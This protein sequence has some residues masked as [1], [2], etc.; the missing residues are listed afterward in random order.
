[1]AM[2]YS[3]NED[4]DDN[5][6]LA[7][8]KE[9]IST[10]YLYFQD[11]YDRFRSFRNFV[12]KETVNDNQRSFLKNLGR[13]MV[14]FNILEAPISSLLG[15][16]A[17]HE[18]SIEVSPSEGVPVDQQV[19]DLVEMNFRHA[20]YVANKNSFS[21]EVYKDTLTGGFS[22]AKVRT[23]YENSMSFKQNIYI[24]KA[25]DSTLCG[26]D[27][28]A[29]HSHKGDGQYCFEIYP[30][31]DKDFNRTFEHDISEIKY[32]NVKTQDDFEGFMWSYKDIKD[33]KTILVAEYYEKKKQRTRI[34]ELANGK[35]MR[36]S[37]YKKMQ[38]LWEENNI[39]EQFPIIKGKPRW[40]TLETICKYVVCENG[41]LD[42]QETDYA[43]LPLIF[44]DGNSI[45]LTVG[46][47]NSTYQMT[48][49]YVYNAKGTQDLKNFAGQALANYL[50]NMV[51]HK[52]IIKKEAIV[53]DA[54]SLEAL[55][56]IQRMNNIIVNAYSE[57]DPNKPIDNPITPVQPVPAPPEIMGAFQITDPTIQTILGG[58]ASNLAKNDNDL[59][60]KAVIETLS[61][62]NAA[63][64]PFVVGYLN[65]LA[66]IATVYIDL[67]PKYLLGKRTLPLR[68]KEGKS[69]YQDIN[70]DSVRLDYE[71]GALKVNIEAGVNFKVSKDRAVSQI[72]SLMSASEELSKFF[73][74]EKGLTLLFKNLN[75]MGGDNL[76]DAIQEFMQQQKQEQ[77]QAMKMQQEAMQNDPAILK[78]KTEQM[79]VQQQGEQNQVENQFKIAQLQID[80]QLAE[81]K[82]M[83]AEAKIS[84]S[85][86][87]QAIRLEEGEVSRFNHSIDNATK[88]A[89]LE[90]KEHQKDMDHHNLN[91]EHRKLD[92][93]GKKK[94]E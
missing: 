28:M 16:F 45:I 21:Y 78:A 58:F 34:V 31:T 90:F 82:L 30:M 7:R 13:P 93:A 79:K 40:T 87:D 70:D 9:N 17:A 63:S 23:D 76:E 66:Q 22:V 47:G 35:V 94:K 71:E 39:V 44:I 55:K 33:S 84:E 83:E 64:M 86:V 72:I 6:E 57:N 75:I 74:S 56:N 65:G 49:P 50:Q 62:S 38:K 88:M 54:D 80:K 41:I 68:D 1:M 19:I 89:E 4:K 53:Q 52:F 37:K 85:Q 14:E 15:E 36:L 91:L 60:G 92:E 77:E 73:N 12:F 27:P 46:R 61:A 26:F 81:A 32:N 5:A 25:F 20:L 42:Y 10:S 2:N 24:E 11:N 48:K 59:S 51:Q 43:F 18:P 69:S 8:I 3:N 67:I 29:R